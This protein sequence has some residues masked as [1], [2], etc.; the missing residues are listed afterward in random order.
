MFGREEMGSVGDGRLVH[1]SNVSTNE[2][3]KVRTTVG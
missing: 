2:D 3:D 1:V